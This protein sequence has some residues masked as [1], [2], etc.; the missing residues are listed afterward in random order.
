MEELA[1]VVDGE[2]GNND[3]Y[4][5]IF[6]LSLHTVWKRLFSLL[7]FVF[8][9]VSSFVFLACREKLLSKVDNVDVKRAVNILRGKANEI[10][11]SAWSCLC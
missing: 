1:F 8:H 9:V 11:V 7:F 10:T 4:E 5:W 2:N 6:H 3:I